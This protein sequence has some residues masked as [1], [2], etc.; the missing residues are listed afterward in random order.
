[1]IKFLESKAVLSELRAYPIEA[2]PKRAY[3]KR[4][5]LLKNCWSNKASSKCSKLSRQDL[6]ELMEGMLN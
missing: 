3:P 5:H 2:Y 6:L 1:M 4:N